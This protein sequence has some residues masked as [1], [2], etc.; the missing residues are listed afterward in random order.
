MESNEDG[1]TAHFPVN[2]YEAES[3]QEK[4]IEGLNSGEG[5]AGQLCKLG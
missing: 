2:K 5:S 3:T 1:N 4:W